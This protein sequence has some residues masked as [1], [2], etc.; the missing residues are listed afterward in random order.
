ML[1]VALVIAVATADQLSK[2]AV[3]RAVPLGGGV[4]VGSGLLNI[5][6][7]RNPGAAF[8]MLNDLGPTARMA[9]F[10]S[11]SIVA[12]VVITWLMLTSS[13]PLYLLIGY[14]LFVG[15]IAGNLTDRIRLGEVTDFLDF[16]IGVW[17]WPAFNLADASLCVG[18]AL[19]LIH[20]LWG[21]ADEEEST[22]T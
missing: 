18:T 8:S 7:V 11:V 14:A 6:H 16:S 20:V 10:G 19:F 12:T 15:G 21:G 2:W 4:T 13:P 5:V 9:F 3:A 22:D 1:F 17:H